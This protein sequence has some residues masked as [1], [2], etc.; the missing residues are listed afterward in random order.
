MLILGLMMFSLATL[1]TG[2]AGSMTSLIFYRVMTGIGEGIFWPAASLEV[3]NV[4]SEKQRTTVMSLYWMGYPI[5]DS[6]DGRHAGP[7][8][9][10]RVVCSTW[11]ARWACWWRCCIWCW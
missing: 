6:T 1:L 5:A 3:A 11:R 10:W 8:F 9:G 7:I 2:V 4:T